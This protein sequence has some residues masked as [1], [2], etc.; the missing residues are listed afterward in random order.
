MLT[1]FHSMFCVHVPFTWHL[2]H[3]HCL[4]GK[5]QFAPNRY[6]I[7]MNF[8][9]IFY[10][11]FHYKGGSLLEAKIYRLIKISCGKLNI[12]RGLESDLNQ[13]RVKRGVF[14]V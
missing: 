9:T 11:N 8:L 7:R 10:L 14:D 4:I 13:E 3:P 1:Q 2:Q 6:S 12:S 5:S